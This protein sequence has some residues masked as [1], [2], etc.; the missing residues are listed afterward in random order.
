MIQV[1]NCGH[2][3]RHPKPCNF[4]Y[5][6]GLPDYLLLLVKQEAWYCT[7]GERSVLRPN[8]LI[9]FPPNTHIHYGCDVPGYNDDWVHFTTDG[10]ELELLQKL[11]PHLGHLISPLDFH[12][13][14]EY[15]RLMTNL[16]HTASP[17]H[18]PMLDAFMHLFL[19]AL[20]EEAENPRDALP[21]QY[22]RPFCKLRTKIY[23][24][25][26]DTPSIGE[27]AASLCLSLSYFQHL[28]KKFFHCSCGQDIIQARLELA[29]Y[30]LQNSEISIREL[31][32]FC[33]YNNELHF[34]RQF[35][36]FVGKTPS[37]YRN[38]L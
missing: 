3:S 36:K 1:T 16:Y 23:D 10:E 33:G 30:H 32:A 9:C 2:D 17:Y 26:A 34:M 31:A 20:L 15:I 29:K 6:Q 24:N 21:P 12:K 35:K 19:Y 38:S 37:E 14:S 5:R 18:A 22:Y 27:L 8:T 25:P 4:E 28:Y 11:Q 13:L 7:D